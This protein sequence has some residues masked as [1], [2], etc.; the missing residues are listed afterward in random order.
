MSGKWQKLLS[1]RCGTVSRPCQAFDRRSPLREASGD[2]RSGRVAW[3]GDHATTHGRPRHNALPLTTHH[4]PAS[5]QREPAG[6]VW[7]AGA[8]RVAVEFGQ[9]ADLNGRASGDETG[10]AYARSAGPVGACAA[11]R[12]DGAARSAGATGATDSRIAIEPVHR[13]RRAA[14]GDVEAA[15]LAGAAS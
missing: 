11:A 8:R 7:I 2:P 15:A 14:G 12:A 5:K 3:S 6:E 4:S 1:P 10:A 13:Q 9:H